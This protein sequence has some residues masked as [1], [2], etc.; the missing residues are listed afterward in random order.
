MVCKKGERGRTVGEWREFR[1]GVLD[2]ARPLPVSSGVRTK[3][4]SCNVALRAVKGEGRGCGQ[5]LALVVGPDPCGLDGPR[6]LGLYL[7]G[8]PGP[9]ERLTNRCL[10]IPK[11][12]CKVQIG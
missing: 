7:L 8:R 9:S 11:G 4:R 10:E 5:P 12:S 2:G 1:A 6:L 3:E